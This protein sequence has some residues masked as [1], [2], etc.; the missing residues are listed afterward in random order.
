[1]S[2]AVGSR[3]IGIVVPKFQLLVLLPPLKR[4]DYPAIGQ[5]FVTS[6]SCLVRGYRS[7]NIDL[8]WGWN[9]WKCAGFGR[10]HCFDP[11]L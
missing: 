4:Y 3:F 8:S 7:L 5:P 6:G 1:L 2:L 9:G 11:V 10:I